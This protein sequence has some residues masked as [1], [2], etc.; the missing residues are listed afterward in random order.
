MKLNSESFKR[1][2]KKSN[3]RKLI[4]KYRI[5]ISD[6]RQIS[7]GLRHLLSR[8]LEKNP[9]KRATITEL[10]ENEWINEGCKT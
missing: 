8:M 4:T 6:S 5:K 2:I 1:S 7:F 10:R 3:N 9:E